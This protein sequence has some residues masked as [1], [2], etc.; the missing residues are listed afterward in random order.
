MRYGFGIGGEATSLR[1]LKHEGECVFCVSVHD[2]QSRRLC[3]SEGTLAFEEDRSK[4]GKCCLPAG[5]VSLRGSRP[6]MSGCL[7]KR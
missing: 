3:W 6:E 2:A 7:G 1:G 4:N 5:H